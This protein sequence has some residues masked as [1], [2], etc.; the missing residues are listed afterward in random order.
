MEQTCMEIVEPDLTFKGV[1]DDAELA[2]CT[3]LGKRVA[4]GMK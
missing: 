2:E 1:T 4:N 3:Q